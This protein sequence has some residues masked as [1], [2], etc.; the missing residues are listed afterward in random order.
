MDYWVRDVEANEDNHFYLSGRKNL[1]CQFS[2]LGQNRYG[3]K[4]GNLKV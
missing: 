3:K 2:I 1:Q 4:F